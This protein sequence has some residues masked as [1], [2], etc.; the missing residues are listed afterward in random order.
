MPPKGKTDNSAYQKLKKDIA[1][2]S[3]GQLYIFHGEESYL[4]DFYLG[5]M[6]EKLLPAGME[7]FNLHTLSGKEFDVKKLQE[8][9]DCLPMMSSRTL[10][11][12]SDFDLYKGDK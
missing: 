9:V 4:R 1:E 11:V 12:V 10:I 5:R 6:K 7:E 8:L 3:I 2:D